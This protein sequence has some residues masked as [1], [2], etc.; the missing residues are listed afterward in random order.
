M[1]KPH[2]VSKYL[3]REFETDGPLGQKKLFIS[4]KADPSEAAGSILRAGRVLKAGMLVLIAGDVRWSG[5][6]ATEARFLGSTYAFSATWVSLASMTGAP[7]VPVF[8][9][10][11]PG[12]SHL[13][14][15]LPAFRVPPGTSAGRPE[16][17]AWVQ[18]C[19]DA[20]ESRV[21][22]CPENSND[23]L[24]WDDPDDAQAAS[25][26]LRRGRSAPAAG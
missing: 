22:L 1:E 25:A 13:L 3:G 12:G 15:F 16:A 20:I 17:A 11:E 6:H 8:C 5:P 24:F 19:L 21:K 4:R 23:Y 7:V 9:R 26:R 10:M 2:H 14:E 18:T